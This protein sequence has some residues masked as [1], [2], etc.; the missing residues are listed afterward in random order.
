LKKNFVFIFAIGLMTLISACG[1]TQAP[2][3]D[4]TGSVIPSGYVGKTNSLAS[5]SDVLTE[6]KTVYEKTCSACHGLT[7]LGDGP[8][9]ISLIPPP[10]ILADFH[11]TA[12]DE[13][14]F[15]RISEGK[16]G[17]SMVGWKTVL[18]EDQI[19]KVISYVRTFD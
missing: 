6:G 12:D 1:D 4:T 8:A 3:E 15:W 9:S 17:T 18:T 11:K 19:W 5:S 13:L 7:G 2:S 10:A 16:D 14:L